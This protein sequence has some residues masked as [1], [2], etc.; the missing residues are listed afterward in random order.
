MRLKRVAPRRGILKV[1]KNSWFFLGGNNPNQV[2][3][4]TEKAQYYFLCIEHDRGYT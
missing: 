4:C 2:L 3:D 1:D